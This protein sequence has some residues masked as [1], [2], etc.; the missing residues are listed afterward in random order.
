PQ[1]GGDL[2]DEGAGAAGAAAV[3]PHIG[4]GQGAV[5]LLAEEDDLGV[6][7][8]QLHGGAGGGVEGPD[9]GAV[10]H[11]LLDIAG[12]HLVGQGP[13]ARQPA[14]RMGRPANLSRISP[15]SWQ[16]VRRCSAWW[17]W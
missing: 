9:G 13:P 16:R 3:H 5:L 15:S 12:P 1:Q 7:A 8:A 10:G 17:R 6:L 2:V 14:T 11:H 4:G